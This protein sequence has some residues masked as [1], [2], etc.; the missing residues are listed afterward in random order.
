MFAV[1]GGTANLTGLQIDVSDDFAVYTIRP[2][3]N[4]APDGTETATMN[5]AAGK[6]VNQFSV[7]LIPP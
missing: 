4:P 7:E 5:I 2:Q 1:S 3:F 6:C